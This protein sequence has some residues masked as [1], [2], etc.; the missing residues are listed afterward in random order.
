M[1]RCDIIGVAEGRRKTGAMNIVTNQNGH[2]GCGWATQGVRNATL[3]VEDL[4]AKYENIV[5]IRNGDNR[6][7]RFNE[8]TNSVAR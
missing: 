1:G 6:K 8:R 7:S 5:T 3:D 2:A 4:E